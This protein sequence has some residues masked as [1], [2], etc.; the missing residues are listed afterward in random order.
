MPNVQHVFFTNCHCSVGDVV[1]MW[2][3][4]TQL[5]Q[6]TQPGMNS[7]TL[8]FVLQGG[9]NLCNRFEVPL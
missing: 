1:W 4:M 9:N 3:Y 2:P 7:A 5:G 8:F 6:P